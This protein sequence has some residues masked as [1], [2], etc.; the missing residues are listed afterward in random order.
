MAYVRKKG[1]GGQSYYQLVESRRVDGQPRQKV[2]IH[3][4][5]YPAVEDALKEKLDRLR[6]MCALGVV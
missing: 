3:L 4:G 5:R 2:L 1:S 6:Q